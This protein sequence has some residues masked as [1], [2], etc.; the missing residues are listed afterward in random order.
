MSEHYSLEQGTVLTKEGE[1]DIIFAILVQ[2]KVVK[3]AGRC[4]VNGIQ[5]KQPTDWAFMGR[6]FI[7]L[8][9]VDC[10]W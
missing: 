6:Y 2:G 1:K 8:N 9:Y 5:R 4:E 10:F 7:V 3:Y